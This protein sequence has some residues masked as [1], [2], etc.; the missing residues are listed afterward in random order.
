MMIRI[1][2]TWGTITNMK[3]KEII[4]RKKISWDDVPVG[5]YF[6]ILYTCPE[7]KPSEMIGKIYHNTMIKNAIDKIGGR[8]PSNLV[9]TKKYGYL[10]IHHNIYML[11]YEYGKLYDPNDIFLYNGGIQFDPR[12]LEPKSTFVPI[13][14]SLYG[15]YKERFE[16]IS[17]VDTRV[18]FDG[19]QVYLDF[20]TN[21]NI[22]ELCRSRRFEY[23]S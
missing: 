9:K 13:Y 22:G 7:D 6:T 17:K 15:G 14:N 12:T 10:Q 21:E 5:D 19:S 3:T 16:F 8:L 20:G 4:I 2:L 11:G 18:R 23:L 1:F